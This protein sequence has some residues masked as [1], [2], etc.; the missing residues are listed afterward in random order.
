[1]PSDDNSD[2]NDFYDWGEDEDVSDDDDDDDEWSRQNRKRLKHEFHMIK[3]NTPLSPSWT[4]SLME[5]T[6]ISLGQTGRYWV[7]L[8]EGILT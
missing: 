2:E 6:I 8:L 4:S 7:G 3:G 5:R 1:M